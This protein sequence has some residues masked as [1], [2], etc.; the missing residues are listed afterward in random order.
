MIDEILFSLLSL[1]LPFFIWL[2]Q[3][4]RNLERRIS[5]LEGKIDLIINYLNM[6]K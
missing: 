6:K 5:C 4:I 3:T 2:I 1:F